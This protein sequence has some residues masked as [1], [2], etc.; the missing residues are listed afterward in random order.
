MY[1]YLLHPD[2]ISQAIFISNINAALFALPAL[3]VGSSDDISNLNSKFCHYVVTSKIDLSEY[4][5]F[6]SE[7]I[8]K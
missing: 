5:F 1:L 2:T 8:L 7:S 3:S 6:L 4:L